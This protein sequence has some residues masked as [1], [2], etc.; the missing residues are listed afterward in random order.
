[1]S[2]SAS[3]NIV[4]FWFYNLTA[5]SGLI[6]WI[7]SPWQPYL[8]WFSLLFF[9]AVILVNGFAVFIHGNWNTSSFLVAYIGI[10]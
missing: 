2:V 8:A 4:F 3:S 7:E 10:P 9:T 6:T 1:M 5:V